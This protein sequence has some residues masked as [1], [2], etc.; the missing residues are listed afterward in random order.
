MTAVDLASTL[1][2]TSQ[3]ET[4]VLRSRRVRGIA[5]ARGEGAQWPTDLPEGSIVDR[6][7]AN[8]KGPPA[9]FSNAERK[10]SKTKKK[11]KK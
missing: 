7:V 10:Q 4:V 11:Q 5:R 3:S 8:L 9:L 2:A 1:R 6:K